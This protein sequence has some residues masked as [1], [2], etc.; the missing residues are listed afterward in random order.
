MSSTDVVVGLSISEPGEDELVQLGLSEMHVRHA[1]IEIVRHLLARGWAVAYGGDLRAAGYT[2]AL[3]DLVRTYDLAGVP[4]PDRVL[5]YLAWP[6]WLDVTA[7]QRAELANIATIKEV[8]P[9]EGAPSSLPALPDR[10]PSDLLW[11]SLA[12]TAMRVQMNSEISARIVLGGRVHGQQGLYPGVAEE[13]ALSLRSGVP[14]YVI[15]GFGGCG[16]V[17]ASALTGSRPVELSPD[18]Q[19]ERTPRYAELLDAARSAGRAPSFSDMID[20]FAE[21]SAENLN[22]GLGA[23]ENSRL[24]ATDDID[25]ATALILRGLRYMTG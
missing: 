20:T 15:G 8:A 7:A 13:A 14:L 11:Y 5:S 16:R 10:R 24:F 6:I 4:G 9:P 21:A 1:F 3:F 22:N 19:L 25:E 18:Y 23:T 17:V 2:E 12:L